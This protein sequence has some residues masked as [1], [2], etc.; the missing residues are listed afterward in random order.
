MRLER[1]ICILVATRTG[2]STVEARL[3]N[4]AVRTFDRTVLAIGWEIQPG[5]G[6]EFCARWQSR[7][8]INACEVVDIEERPAD[9]SSRSSHWSTYRL[10]WN[11]VRGQ[12]PHATPNDGGLPSRR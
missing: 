11:A 1:G 5:S 3:R 4:V 10:I 2:L 6:N 9:D 8:S 7:L 12:T